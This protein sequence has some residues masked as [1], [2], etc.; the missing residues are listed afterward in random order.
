MFLEHTVVV[1]CLYM[2]WI[3]GRDRQCDE[4]QCHIL[5]ALCTVMGTLQPSV[6]WWWSNWDEWWLKL[7]VAVVS[8]I[9][10]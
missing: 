1:T 9:D 8:S 3:R 5:T 10:W 2:A 4:K 6:E 7:K